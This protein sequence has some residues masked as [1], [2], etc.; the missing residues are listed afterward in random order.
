M[1]RGFKEKESDGNTSSVK[2]RETNSPAILG[3]M[4]NKTFSK[5]KRL[6]VMAATVSASMDRNRAKGASASGGVL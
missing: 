1:I 2:K 5:P 4:F 3:R 6:Y